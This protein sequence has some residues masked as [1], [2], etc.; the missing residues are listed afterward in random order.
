MNKITPA[1]ALDA[2]NNLDDYLRMEGDFVDNALGS[3]EVLLDFILQHS[4]PSDLKDE[5][6]I[7]HLKWFRTNNV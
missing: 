5:E 2:L 4:T 1:D 6:S 7:R 3:I